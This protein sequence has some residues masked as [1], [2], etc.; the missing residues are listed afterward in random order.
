V[1]RVDQEAF[2]KIA[3]DVVRRMDDKGKPELIED[4]KNE[5]LNHV[6]C[7]SKSVWE[8][9]CSIIRRTWKFNRVPN[10][11]HFLDALD[12]AMRGQSRESFSS[13]NVS[14]G[15]CLGVGVL[16]VTDDLGYRGI[17]DCTCENRVGRG[18]PRSINHQPDRPTYLDIPE[19]AAALNVRGR[20]AMD[21][22]VEPR[23]T[24]GLE[25]KRAALAKTVKII[26]RN[27]IKPVADLQAVEEEE[28]PF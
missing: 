16:F 23:Y 9:A 6:A 12:G 3:L 26:A 4:L 27:T 14:C 17:V 8:D 19:P 20:S 13:V 28:C 7:P 21:R 22:A 10:L 15:I 5:I 25:E 11:A 2:V 24:F 18:D 1:N